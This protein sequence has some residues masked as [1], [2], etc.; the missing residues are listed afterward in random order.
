VFIASIGANLVPE[1]MR[2]AKLLWNANV[3]SEYSHQ[4]NPKF[5]KQLDETLE[6]GIPFMVVFGEDERAKGVVKLKNMRAH[7]EDEVPLEGLVEAL[8][9]QGCKAIPP[10]ADLGFLATLRG[11]GDGAQSSTA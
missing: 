8:L 7:T 4:D 11:E 6:R 1:R 2:V 5:K 10:A 3:P 9:A